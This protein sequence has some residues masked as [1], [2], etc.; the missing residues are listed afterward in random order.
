M[1]LGIIVNTNDPETAWNAL[2][3]GNETLTAGNEVKVFLLGR[4]VEI[5]NIK[6]NNFDVGKV[7]GKFLNGRGELLACGTCLESGQQEASRC[8]I[9]T[10]LDLVDMRSCSD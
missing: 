5:M 6:E 9:S 7:L 4:G 2:R 8:P 1:K 3:L 10:M